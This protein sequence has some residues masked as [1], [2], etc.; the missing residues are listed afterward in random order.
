MKRQTTSCTTRGLK[1]GHCNRHVALLLCRPLFVISRN[2]HLTESLNHASQQINPRRGSAF[3]SLLDCCGTILPINSRKATSA[4][5][6]ELCAPAAFTLDSLPVVHCPLVSHHF[7]SIFSL[8]WFLTTITNVIP[9]LS[10]F[11]SYL[12]RWDVV[13][14]KL[15]YKMC[16]KL[17]EWRRGSYRRRRE[18]SIHDGCGRWES[19]CGC[20]MDRSG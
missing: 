11:W 4:S 13:R 17:V 8:P 6:D 14:L 2:D 3:G 12:C 15:W 20:L 1:A 10:D 7:L 16:C 5:I 19:W 9:C 18:R